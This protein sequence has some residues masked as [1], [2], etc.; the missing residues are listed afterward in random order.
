MDEIISV[1]K[2][3]RRAIFPEFQKICAMSKVSLSLATLSNRAVPSENLP[4]VTSTEVLVAPITIQAK[5]KSE[6]KAITPR[7]R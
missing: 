5:G 6:R 3:P 1:A 7:K 4:L 2:P